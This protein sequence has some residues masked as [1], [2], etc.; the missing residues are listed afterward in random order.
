MPLL[1]TDNDLPNEYIVKPSWSPTG[2]WIAFLNESGMFGDLYLI[3]PDGTGLV[4]LTDTG[5]L[6]RDGN[7]VWSPDG[8]QLAYSANPDGNIEIF[9][10]DVEAALQGIAAS[11][12]ISTTDIPVRNLVTSWSPDGSRLAFSS[13]RDGNTEI[14]LMD[15]DG[16]NIVRLTDHPLSD[17]EPDFSP[18]G[19]QI[20]FLSNREDREFEI[21]I[22][23]V[24][25]AIQDPATA[26]L[27]RLTDH[28]GDKAGPVWSPVP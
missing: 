5:D 25:E 26:T 28:K 12:Q 2:E 7:L 4:R 6:S 22:L 27:S 24:A 8:K 23:K 9:V 15:P 14:Y 10:L 20:V 17:N 16:S 21:Y 18:D 19:S 13:D 1:V 3:H 11:Q